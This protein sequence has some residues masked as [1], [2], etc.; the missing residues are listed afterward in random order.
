MIQQDNPK[1][2]GKRAKWIDEKEKE[3]RRREG[4]CFR[5]GRTGCVVA[6]CPLLPARSPGSARANHSQV[7]KSKP[8]VK[9]LVE[10]TEDEESASYDQTE[11]DEEELKE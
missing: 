9:A 2:V 10:D 4:R 3:R 6:E 1:L 5:C 8:V 11:T 7:K